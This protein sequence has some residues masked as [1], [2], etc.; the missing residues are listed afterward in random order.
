M[1]DLIGE[2]KQQIATPEPADLGPGP[3]PNVLPESALNQFIDGF[4][5]KSKLPS[6]KGKLIRGLV[7]LW[8]DHLDAAHHLVQN[9]ENADGS[10]VH[11]IMH[12]REPDYSN[13]KYWFRRV[14]KHPCFPELAERVAMLLA[15]SKDHAL[16]GK[17]IRNGE[18][19]S[20]VFIDAC[21]QAAQRPESDLQQRLLREIQRIE[22]EVLLESFW[23]CGSPAT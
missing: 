2:F 21:E 7:P 16:A 6:A 8:H 18:W 22:F 15:S 4:L 14:G 11:G 9:L 20:F 3:R 19:D 1:S 23:R 10:L 17:L 12:R 13:A 5:D